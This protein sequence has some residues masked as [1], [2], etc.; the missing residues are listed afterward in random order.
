MNVLKFFQFKKGIFYFLCL[1]TVARLRI[2]RVILEFVTLGRVSELRTFYLIFLMYIYLNSNLF[3]MEIY[4]HPQRKNMKKNHVK[5][6][7]KFEYEGSWHREING[8]ERRKKYIL[9]T[10]AKKRLIV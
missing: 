6:G 5:K 8:I 3:M 2:K 4:R 7:L 1:A 10:K 9:H